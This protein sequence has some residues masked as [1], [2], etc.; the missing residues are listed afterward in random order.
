MVAKKTSLNS[1]RIRLAGIKSLFIA[2]E[3]K[4]MANA[5]GATEGGP[6]VTGF[7]EILTFANVTNGVE[8]A[9][10]GAIQ[11]FSHYPQEPPD[12]DVRGALP[13]RLRVGVDRLGHPGVDQARRDGVDP[14]AV[15]A[16]FQGGSDRWLSDC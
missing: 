7:D 16:P 13:P 1:D 2:A 12:G 9:L 15:T 14:D 8:A 11:A 3:T 5:F 4:K 6:D 10:T